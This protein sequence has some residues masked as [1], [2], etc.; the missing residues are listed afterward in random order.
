MRGGTEKMWRAG[1]RVGIGENRKE[2]KGRMDLFSVCKCIKLTQRLFLV[3]K[4]LKK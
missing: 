2:S 4:L 3:L 1:R